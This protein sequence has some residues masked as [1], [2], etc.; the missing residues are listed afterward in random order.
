MIELRTISEDNYQQCLG[1]K[2]SV[3]NESFVD[4]VAYSLAEAWVF[5]R[6][7]RPFALYENDKMI[8]FVSMYIG[9]EN[10]QIINFLIDDTF[11][12][13]GLG[14]EAAKVCISYLQKEH[15]AKR[16][17]VPVE[18]ENMSAQKFWGKLGFRFSDNVE[19]GYVFMRLHLA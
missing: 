1:L 19:D 12:K 18:Q 17:S 4:S 6:D 2:A 14:T 7:T 16:I 10:H 8:G 15:G 11:Q 9:E 5:Y 13:K 3:E